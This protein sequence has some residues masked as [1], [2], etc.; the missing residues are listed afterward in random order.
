M[1]IGVTFF[2]AAML[3][4][5]TNGEGEFITRTHVYKTSRIERPVL[6]WLGL[7][8]VILVAIGLPSWPHDSV[9]R[10]IDAQPEVI[11]TLPRVLILPQ[12]IET[13]GSSQQHDRH[14]G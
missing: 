13:A 2:T 4:I 10:E 1:L 6:Y 7:A 9:A 11:R 5:T 12:A 3:V 8:I 14:E